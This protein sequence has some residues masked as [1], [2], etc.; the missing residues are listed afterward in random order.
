[1]WK[2]TCGCNESQYE[3]I[4]CLCAKKN[5]TMDDNEEERRHCK[6]KE[7]PPGMEEVI[8]CY[9]VFFTHISSNYP[10]VNTSVIGVIKKLF[11]TTLIVPLSQCILI[12]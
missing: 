8:W 5:G 3:G 11:I 9:V 4:L 6:V 7:C 10:D 1:M 2:R 12:Y